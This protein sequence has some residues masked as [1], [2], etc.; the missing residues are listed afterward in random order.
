MIAALR[1]RLSPIA[2]LLALLASLSACGSG[3]REPAAEP[4]PARVA[5]PLVVAPAPLIDDLPSPAGAPPRAEDVLDSLTRLLVPVPSA[6]DCAYLAEDQPGASLGAVLS[7]YVRDA[8]TREV[9]CVA[10]GDG[11]RCHVSLVKSTGGED[12]EYG[13]FLELRIDRA[14]IDPRSIVCT[15]AG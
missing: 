6:G 12:A 1:M 4:P 7:P 11:F 10:D 2:R 14:G 8:D 3:E 15:L 5:E 9:A 13:V